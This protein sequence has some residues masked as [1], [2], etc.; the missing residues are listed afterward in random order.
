MLDTSHF[1]PKA[2]AIS[3]DHM[4]LTELVWEQFARIVGGISMRTAGIE[5][6]ELMS[7][8]CSIVRRSSVGSGLAITFDDGPHQEL[9]WMILDALDNCGV[10]ATFFCVGQNAIN[11]PDIVR[12]IGAAGHDIGN[13]TM[14]HPDL[15]RVS[16]RVLR[17]EILDCQS[18]LQDI[19]GRRINLF[20]APFGHFRWELRH[21]THFGLEHLIG[22]DIAPPLLATA[23]CTYAEYIR[24][25]ATDGS[26]ILLHDR[27]CGVERSTA[28]DAVRA[29]AGSLAMFVGPF[30]E[31]GMRFTT[32]SQQIHSSIRG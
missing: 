1:P 26:I 32:V 19:L 9:T 10:K 11:H 25:R 24:C 13:H 8:G 28:N 20:R 14:T 27:L 29:V 15:H 12:A 5:F 30:K 23:P 31:R 7:A 2:E 17:A 6:D 18:A 22:W 3:E 16:P 4:N 21:P